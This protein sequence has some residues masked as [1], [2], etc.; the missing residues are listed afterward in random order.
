MILQATLTHTALLKIY[1]LRKNHV[2]SI[3][4]EPF[5]SMNVM[6][7]WLLM[8][9]G[10]KIIIFSASVRDVIR[11]PDNSFKTNDGMVTLKDWRNE[12]L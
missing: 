10:K 12:F 3:K 6:L 2:T 11:L 9:N 7:L 1:H 8:H 5:L 4:S